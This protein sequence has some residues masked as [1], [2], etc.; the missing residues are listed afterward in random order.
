MYSI[1]IQMCWIILRLLPIVILQHSQYKFIYTS[2][3]NQT[4]EQFQRPA[5]CCTHTGGC[6]HKLVQNVKRTISG[7]I[8]HDD[9]KFVI[10]SVTHAR[11]FMKL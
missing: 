4:E 10:F 9:F 11:V 7:F 6:P 2:N 3:N 5:L 1:K 8:V